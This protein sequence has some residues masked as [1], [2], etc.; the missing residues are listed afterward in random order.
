[1]RRSAYD[2]ES[3]SGVTAEGRMTPETPTTYLGASKV[4]A[5][6][7]VPLRVGPIRV[8]THSGTDRSTPALSD[9]IVRILNEWWGR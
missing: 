9:W 5:I 7:G 2:S 6:R 8:E 4:R 3:S 1:V